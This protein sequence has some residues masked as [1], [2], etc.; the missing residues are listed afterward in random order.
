[1]SHCVA[2]SSETHFRRSLRLCFA[3]RVSLLSVD[4]RLEAFNLSMN[5]KFDFDANQSREANN[6]EK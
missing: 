1:M 2:F 5:V 4:S 3:A 6:R